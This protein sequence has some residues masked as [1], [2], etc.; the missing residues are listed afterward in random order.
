MRIKL[1]LSALEAVAT[2]CVVIAVDHKNGLNSLMLKENFGVSISQIS[3]L[4]PYLHSEKFL[5]DSL[6][7]NMMVLECEQNSTQKN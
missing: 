5:Y 6:N 7:R 3:E 1:C 4:V 2:N